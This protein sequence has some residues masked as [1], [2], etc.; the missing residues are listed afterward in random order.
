MVYLGGNININNIHQNQIPVRRVIRGLT[1]QNLTSC[2]G[3][4]LVPPHWLIWLVRVIVMEDFFHWISCWGFSGPFSQNPAPDHQVHSEVIV[5]LPVLLLNKG[6][7]VILVNCWLVYDLCYQPSIYSLDFV[8]LMS[9]CSLNSSQWWQRCQLIAQL[10]FSS[11]VRSEDE[12]FTFL[13]LWFHGTFDSSCNHSDKHH[14]VKHLWPEQ[15]ISV[16]AA[17]KPVMCFLAVS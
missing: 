12:L 3:G 8:V 7:Y 15:I 2:P 5:Q 17:F 14:E 6:D 11:L 10:F 16:R 13:H 4:V 9:V 1:N